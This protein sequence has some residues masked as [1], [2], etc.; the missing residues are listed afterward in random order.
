MAWRLAKSLEK[1]RSQV[2]AKHPKRS[3]ASDG[4]I[5][6]EKHASRDSDHNPWVKD[7]KMGVVTAIDITNDPA[8]GCDAHKL[9]DQLRTKK[10]PRIK[11]VIS[12][13]RI[14]S[15][16]QD[17]WM[18]RPYS[19]SNKHVKHMHISVNASKVLFDDTVEWD[20]G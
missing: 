18:W 7:G 5:G 3:K 4:A 11:Y 10:D 13:G 12:N 2:N 20:I 14:F 6:D 1:L 8:N 19:G 16:T 15:A 17:P 9:A